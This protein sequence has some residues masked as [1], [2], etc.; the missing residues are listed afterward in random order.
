MKKNFRRWLALIMTFVLAVTSIMFATN[1]SLLATDEDGVYTS[2]PVQEEVVLEESEQGTEEG[3][4][5]AVQQIDLSAPEGEADVDEGAVTEEA[6]Q[7][8]VEPEEVIAM[9][10]A[11]FTAAAS[12]INVSVSAPE[13]AFPEGTTMKVKAVSDAK[14]MALAEDAASD[15]VVDAKAVDIT[16]YDADGNE[17][18]PQIPIDVKFSNVGLEGKKIESVDV[19]HVDDKGEAALVESDASKNVAEFEAESF[20]IYLIVA[21]GWGF[22]ASETE[23]LI[24]ETVKVKVGE[25]ITVQGEVGDGNNR[26]NHEWISSDTRIAAVT[27]NSSQPNRATVRG[28]AGSETPITITHRYLSTD[29]KTW[30]EEKFEVIVEEDLVTVTFKPNG[31]TGQDYTMKIA[32]GG[33]LSLPDPATLGMLNEGTT[34]VGW[35]TS[36]D[37]E[38]VNYT[39][40]VTLNYSTDTTLYAKW[41]DTTDTGKSTTAY[42]FVRKSGEI[43]LEPATRTN[44]SQYY[45][46]KKCVG[47]ARGVISADCN[48]Q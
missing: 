42:F 23:T 8:A 12:G 9:P 25:S 27:E 11:K 18:Q 24:E 34:F 47:T 3:K 43:L 13:G 14:A 19:Y 10:A 44:P 28:V 21:S 33:S 2:E 7:P 45:P 4:A 37:D 46:A 20:S 29:G 16:F 35:S 36:T 17:V 40:N 15:E 32:K 41:L 6:E 5:Q 22:F 26:N 30:I 48:Q 39:P 38:A 31:A 1:S